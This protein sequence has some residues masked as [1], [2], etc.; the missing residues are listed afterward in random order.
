[1]PNNDMVIDGEEEDVCV[2]YRRMLM[3]DPIISEMLNGN[4][5]FACAADEEIRLEKLKTEQAVKAGKVKVCQFYNS[6]SGCTDHAVCPYIHRKDHSA[7]RDRKR[8]RK[9]G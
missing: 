4:M 1:M 9:T 8:A 7:A 5:S 6:P 2:R 3:N